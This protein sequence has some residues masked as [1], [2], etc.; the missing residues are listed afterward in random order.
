MKQLL[1][2]FVICL[3]GSNANAQTYTANSIVGKWISAA[4]DLEVQVY[5]DK[6][7][8]Y[9]S[10][11]TWFVVKVKDKTMQNYCDIKNPD[12]ALRNRK[13]LGMQ[14]MTGLEYVAENKWENGKIYV[15]RSGK[16]YSVS[17]HLQDINTLI[18]RGFFGIELFGESLTFYKKK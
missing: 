7:G 4:R 15:P 3:F 12:C 11:I 5:L 6:N 9:A 17:V 2:C 10:T 16:T 14:T 18:V 1:I 13:W 8:K